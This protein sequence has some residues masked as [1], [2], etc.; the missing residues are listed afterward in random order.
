MRFSTWQF[1]TGWCLLAFSFSAA[2]STPLEAQASTSRRGTTSGERHT[3]TPGERYRA[4]GLK[5]FFFGS[6]YRNLWTTALE[7]DVLDLGLVGGGWGWSIGNPSLSGSQWT[8][9]CCEVR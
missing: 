2:Y 6:D 1:T 7:A 4:G 8:Q 5:S 9:I 3:V